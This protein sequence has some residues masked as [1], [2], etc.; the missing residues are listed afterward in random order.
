MHPFFAFVPWS[1]ALHRFR[2]LDATTGRWVLARHRAELHDIVQRYQQWQ[3]VGE[4]E[5]R[6]GNSIGWFS[7]HAAPHA[8]SAS[9]A[10]RT[11]ESTSAPTTPARSDDVDASPT[12][13]DERERFLALLF[14]RRYI[15][16]CARRRRFAAMEGAACLSRR[17]MQQRRVV[18]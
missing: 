18:R 13:D 16:W 8:V 15:T 12:I 2:F 6:P 9:D 10:G 7:P 14:L 3:L 5:I 1:L 11:A 17:L 4:P